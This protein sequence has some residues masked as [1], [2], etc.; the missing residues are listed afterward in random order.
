MHRQLYIDWVDTIV[1]KED[2]Y[3]KKLMA[4]LEIWYARLPPGKK[5]GCSSCADNVPRANG[6]KSAPLEDPDGGDEGARPGPAVDGA[7]A[8]G[9]GSAGQCTDIYA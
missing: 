1:S 8:G 6:R 2:S 3:R 9:K 5:R 4:Q 7:G